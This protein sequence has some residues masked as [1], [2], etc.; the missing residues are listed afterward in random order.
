MRRKLAMF[1]LFLGLATVGGV[2]KDNPL[3]D[4]YPRP[5]SK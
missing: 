4:C 3:P 1:F 2:L 5:W